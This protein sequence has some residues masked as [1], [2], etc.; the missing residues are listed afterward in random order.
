MLNKT[1]KLANVEL[2]SHL[3]G[4][5]AICL[6]IV[7]ISLQL[8]S[9]NTFIAN[10]SKDYFGNIATEL[11]GIWITVQIIDRLNQKHNKDSLKSS[12]ISQMS[13]EYNIL[14]SDAVRR[15]RHEGWIGE[16]QDILLA[17]ANLEGVDLSYVNLKSAR[18]VHSNFKSVNI[19]QAILDDV[20]IT[21][22]S[23]QNAVLHNTSFRNAKF[24]AENPNHYLLKNADLIDANFENATFNGA[25]SGEWSESEHIHLQEAR[26]LRGAV[27][28]NGKTY[29]GR[30]YLQGD[31]ADA[32]NND[33]A[34]NDGGSMAGFYG[35]SLNE[36]KN[37]QEW[38]KK[39]G[40]SP[41]DLIAF[42]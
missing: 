24:F 37:G 4:V 3:L 27:M 23:F 16:L 18:L 9:P 28:P 8:F 10:F 38:H 12:L 25:A 31:I 39:H 29:D 36:Y 26:R 11:I 20:E 30:Y 15:L 19:P 1:K 6:V 7:N 13:S 35:V 40:K 22:T 2:I 32:K 17:Y 14:A 21:E 42:V 34:L 5:L 33:Y 41:S